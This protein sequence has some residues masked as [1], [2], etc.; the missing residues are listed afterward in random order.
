MTQLAFDLAQTKRQ[1]AC[2][3][4]QRIVE[5]N[6]R[7]YAVQDFAKRRAAALRVSRRQEAT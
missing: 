3:R 2:E 1:L 6:R 4:L 5:A 7:S